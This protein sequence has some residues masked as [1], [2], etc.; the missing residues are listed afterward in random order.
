[1][2]C[3]NKVRGRSNRKIWLEKSHC[4]WKKGFL[5]RYLGKF[6]FRISFHSK[7]QRWERF[8]NCLNWQ[9]T[10][11]KRDYTALSFNYNPLLC[12]QTGPN[13]P[14]ERTFVCTH[15]HG[16]LTW[17]PAFPLCLW[18]STIKTACLWH[19]DFR[20]PYS[21]PTFCWAETWACHKNCCHDKTLLHSG[22]LS[23][24]TGSWDKKR[25]HQ[26]TSQKTFTAIMSLG[27]ESGGRLDIFH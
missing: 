14:T 20:W 21:Q 4:G 11:G 2:L 3:C 6:T 19:W 10:R 18:N 9:K 15:K 27:P 26:M 17:W 25:W 1:M 5:Q 12:M 16:K 8:M 7:V 23:G 13:N 24:E 22:K